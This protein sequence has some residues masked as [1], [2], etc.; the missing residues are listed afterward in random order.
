M[1]LRSSAQIGVFVAFILSTFIVGAGL[2]AQGV[3]ARSLPVPV[4]LDVCEG[5]CVLHSDGNVGTWIFHGTTGKGFWPKNGA[6]STL[7]IEKFDTEGIRITRENTPDSTAPAFTAVYE[8]VLHGDRI[9]G[10]VI[11]G[12]PPKTIQYPWF[13]TIPVTICDP[14]AHLDADDAF[15]TGQTAVR[16]RQASSAFQCFLLAAIQ[17]QGQAKALTGLMYRDGIGTATNY[18]EAFHWLQAGAIQD[19]YNAE[20]ALSQMYETGVGIPM[21]Q[22]KALAWKERAQNNP[23]MVRQRI[24]AQQQQATQQMMF[25]GLAAVLESLSQ[26]EVYV[27]Y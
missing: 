22:Q 13:A 11:A 23:V 2:R 18:S 25:L 1:K 8:G 26:P 3:P 10:T 20:V 27:V 7:T 14:S 19:D 12:H 4:G 17:G 16:F 21:D 15:E 24:Q 5:G 6:K 9:E